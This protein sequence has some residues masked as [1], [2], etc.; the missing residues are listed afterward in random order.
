[1]T[2]Q[3]SLRD[4]QSQALDQFF[5]NL[6]RAIALETGEKTIPNGIAFPHDYPGFEAKVGTAYRLS[7]G[8]HFVSPQTQELLHYIVTISA[9]WTGEKWEVTGSFHLKLTKTTTLR[10][11]AT[12]DGSHVRLTQDLNP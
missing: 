7:G 1:M 10:Y 9:K 11:D 3:S 6:L 4:R 12:Y 8:V 5:E 2:N